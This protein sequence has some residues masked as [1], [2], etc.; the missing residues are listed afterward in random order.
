LGLISFL[1]STTTATGDENWDGFFG[2]PGAVGAGVNAALWEGGVLF[3]AGHFTSVGGISAT[4][5]AAWDGT[6][7]SPLGGGVG[8]GDLEHVR[9]ITVYDQKVVAAGFFS[10]A[11]GISVSNI[12]QWDGTNW[13]ALE[14]GVEGL[15]RGMATD[16]T[17]LYV[18]GYFIHAGG[19]YAQCIAKWDGTDWSALGR[20][21]PGHVDS[22]AA[23]GGNVYAGGRFILNGD[24]FWATNIARWD[25]TKW[26]ALGKGIGILGSVVRTLL[27]D[28]SGLYAGGSFGSAGE[29]T[30]TNIAKWDGKNWSSLGSGVSREVYSLGHIG[31]S[32]FAGGYFTPMGNG[33][34]NGIAQWDGQVW[35]SLGT[36]IDSPYGYGSVHA[37]AC[38]GSELF[39]G[40]GFTTAGGNPSTNIALWHIPHA[41]KIQRGVDQAVISWAATGTHFILEACAQLPAT[42]WTEVPQAPVLVD[43]QLVVTNQ[44]DWASRFY[45]L[46]RKGG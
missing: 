43:D 22:V 26:S 8:T 6:N 18:G 13:S 29:V 2:V 39:I 35:S 46:R 27:A 4:N 17:N 44:L 30:V 16:G 28:S 33:S 36:G 42:N 34:A 45:R 25:G 1:P 32:L 40:G 11:G 5:I 10:V 9:A 3:V 12:A 7:W 31:N 21:I 38:K 15:I 20:G 24:S 23:D 37:L 19:R 41:L 14:S